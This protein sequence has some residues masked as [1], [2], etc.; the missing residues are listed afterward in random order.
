MIAYAFSEGLEDFCGGTNAA[1]SSARTQ[2]RRSGLVPLGPR[3]TRA[4]VS[5][6]PP[7]RGFFSAKAGWTAHMRTGASGK[8]GQGIYI[9]ASF[10][11][12]GGTR[13]LNSV[14]GYFEAPSSS[15]PGTRLVPRRSLVANFL[16]EK[17]TP[18]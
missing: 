15:G 9:V 10:H 13:R 5:S 14:L 16:K 18:T 17:L 11:I 6:I 4:L 2:G 1:S 8:R 3:A 7:R 12:L